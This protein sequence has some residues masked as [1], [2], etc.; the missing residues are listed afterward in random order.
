V[1]D[2]ELTVV[3]LAEQTAR[4]QEALLWL[5]VWRRSLPFPH[6]PGGLRV[7]RLACF[8]ATWAAPYY[9]RLGI[10]SLHNREPE[11]LFYLQRAQAIAPCPRH[12]LALEIGYATLGLG[13]GRTEPY[14][15]PFDLPLAIEPSFASVVTSV[16]LAEGDWFEAELD[17]WR[18]FLQPGMTAIDVGANVGVYTISAARAVGPQ[19]RVVA[20]E[21]F[22]QC[23]ALL[24]TTCR[25]HG[26]DW[27]TVCRAAAGDRHNRVKLGLRTASETNALLTDAGNQAYEA[28]PALPLDSLVADLG[29]EEVSALK[30]DAEGQELA[31]LMGA[32]GLIERFHPLIIYEY[33]SGQH[34]H[35]DSVGAFLR[36]WGY[37]LHAFHRHRQSLEQ[38]LEQSLEAIATTPPAGILN[39]VAIHGTLA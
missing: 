32:R 16:L 18:Q 23:V 22:S 35:N 31:V 6:V 26:L 12:E 28:V 9:R 21:P 2:P 14:F 37:G 1:P 20:V 8:V 25:H 11:G 19:G 27:V 39:V 10:Y 5:E 7:L 4:N 38:T 15:V 34:G 33:Q 24:E 13:T 3:L 36:E 29:L 17:L 30:I